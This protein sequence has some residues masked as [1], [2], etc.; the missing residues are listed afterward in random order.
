LHLLDGGYEFDVGA[1][2]PP[3]TLRQPHYS[4]AAL[5]NTADFFG[6]HAF[7]WS[8]DAIRIGGVK[9]LGDWS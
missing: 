7:P 8:F 1:S 6:R 3:P 2:W 4:Y 9:T 5:Q